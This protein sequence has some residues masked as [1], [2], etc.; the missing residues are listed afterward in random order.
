MTKTCLGSD[1]ES[2]VCLR[3]AGSYPK[4]KPRA[5]GCSFPFF[6][7]AKTAVTLSYSFHP[8]RA[9]TIYTI[10]A[11]KGR[12][13]CDVLHLSSAATAIA[14]CSA[15]CSIVC[16]GVS[17]TST[18]SSVPEGL[19]SKGLPSVPSSSRRRGEADAKTILI[20]LSEPGF[21][22]PIQIPDSWNSK[23]GRRLGAATEL[24]DHDERV[25]GAPG[26]RPFKSPRESP[27]GPSHSFLDITRQSRP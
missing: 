21:Q 3:K 13:V 9:K 16:A 10:P 7:A 12:E 26:Q 22:I 11:A 15:I 8:L 24:L 18:D 17:R 2:E 19:T 5:P 1:P 4:L 23:S 27:R 14:F 20:G 25:G 6:S